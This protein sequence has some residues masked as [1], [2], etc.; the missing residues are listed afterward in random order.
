MT[1][2]NLTLGDK[3]SFQI[4][5]PVENHL[6]TLSF[7][8]VS[9]RFLIQCFNRFRAMECGNPRN[10]EV[11]Q[12]FHYFSLCMPLRT[13]FVVLWHLYGREEIITF[14]PFILIKMT[15]E[16]CICNLNNIITFTIHSQVFK[17]EQLAIFLNNVLLYV[18]SR[19]TTIHN[20]QQ[21]VE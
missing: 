10:L 20:D 13:Y 12:S 8:Q 7:P 16:W 19:L 18:K 11:T 14:R 15:F 5:E 6:V 1:D 17:I 3:C 4:Q 2:H 9:H 21:Y